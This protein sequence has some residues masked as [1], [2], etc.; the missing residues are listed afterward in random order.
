MQQH[1]EP[2]ANGEVRVVV[3]SKKPD[4][5]N[6]VLTKSMFLLAV[7]DLLRSVCFIFKDHFDSCKKYPITCLQKCGEHKISRDEV[8]HTPAFSS[9]IAVCVFGLFHLGD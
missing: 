8:N 5:Y 1:I 6:L 9:S 4:R 3:E 7:F 2:V